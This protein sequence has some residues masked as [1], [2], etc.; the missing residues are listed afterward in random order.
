MKPKLTQT[1]PLRFP[2]APAVLHTSVFREETVSRVLVLSAVVLILAYIT[3]VSM[4]IVNVI[5]RKEAAE[6]ITATR[7][8]IAQLEHEY[9]ARLESLTVALA[10]ERGLT[11]VSDKQFVQR[12]TAVGVAGDG[13]AR[14]GI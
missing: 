4:T 13:A 12:L 5:A 8:T 11:P 14:N 10:E 1:I 3:M 7:A 2:D 6:Q 9:F